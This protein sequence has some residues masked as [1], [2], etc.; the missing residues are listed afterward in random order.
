MF[1]LLL[2]LHRQRLDYMFIPKWREGRKVG[3]ITFASV[4]DDGLFC[5]DKVSKKHGDVCVFAR[6]PWV[7][8]IFPGCL[9]LQTPAQCPWEHRPESS[10]TVTDLTFVS[11]LEVIAGIQRLLVIT[12]GNLPS[13]AV[14]F[15]FCPIDW[16][17]SIAASL[18]GVCLVVLIHVLFFSIPPK[19]N[20]SS[21]CTCSHQ[22]HPTR[23]DSCC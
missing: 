22:L 8:A 14:I 5:E 12:H 1:R 21:Y 3:V 19:K 2:S 20:L 16:V 23:W 4:V 17:W 9:V 7:S 10:V 15:P 6:Q 13:L 18:L 11:M